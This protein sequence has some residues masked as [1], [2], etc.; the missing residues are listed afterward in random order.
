[1]HWNS[2]ITVNESEVQSLR[3]K[4][5]TANYNE[6]VSP[7]LVENFYQF[8]SIKL[9]KIVPIQLGVTLFQLY[10]LGV[11]KQILLFLVI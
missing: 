8:N 7:E 1:M 4:I 11:L 2:N 5:S 6:S 9:I 3:S 10:Y